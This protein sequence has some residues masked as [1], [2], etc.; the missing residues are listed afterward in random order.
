MIS[1][2]QNLMLKYLKFHM[3]LLWWD[4]EP[5]TRNV[6]VQANIYQKEA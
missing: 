1:L 2:E 4:T 5:P 3:A 6:A